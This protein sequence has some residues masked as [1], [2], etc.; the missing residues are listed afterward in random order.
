MHKICGGILLLLYSVFCIAKSNPPQLI[1]QI[2]IDQLR[3]DLIE[4]HKT[5]F[6]DKG[7]N[8]LLQHAI[9]FNNAHQPHA[10]TTTCVGH[11]SISTGS[12]PSLHGILDNEWYDRKTQ[13]LFYCVEDLNSPL[14]PTQHTRIK[15]PGRSPKSIKQSTLS[16]ELMLAK[17]GRAFAV[18]FKDRGAIT[19]GGHVGKAFWFDKKNGGFVTSQYYYSQYPDWVNAWNKAYQATEYEWTLANPIATY[20]NRNNKP[21][22]HN[23]LSFGQTFP[24]HVVNP[25]SNDYFKSVSRTP[26]GDQ[27]TADFAAQLLKNEHLGQSATQTDYLAVSFSSVDAVGHQ[28]GPNSL[29]AEDNL[30]ALDKTLAA[31]L[32]TLDK[33]VGLKNTLIIL[34]ADHG[35][36]DG[37]SYLREHQIA[38]I[39]P[40]NIANTMKF[41]RH[42]LMDRYQLPS[43]TLMS[44]TP[45][46]IYLNH[47]LIQ[48]RHL[49]TAEVSQYVAE[50]L[51]TLPGI[52]RAYP[53][54]TVAQDWLTRKVNRMAFPHRA[55]DIYIVQPPYQSYGAK[56]EDRVAHGS[57]WQYDSYIPLLFVH[58]DF[59]PQLISRPVFSVDIAPTL[60]N[61][62]KIKAPSG[63]VGQPLVEVIQAYTELKH[64]KA[65]KRN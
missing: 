63:V 26:K 28:F 52:F 53:L 8:Y 57:P 31:F 29:E 62:L 38:E 39:K 16:D 59:K 33:Q 12:Y 35:V 1:V 37:P 61:L 3:G 51:S 6:G 2:V 43:E 64:D 14:L 7:F 27:L 44:I 32:V 30:L 42:L 56:S 23:Y 58:P 65:G 10:N 9:D 34:T 49:Y 13:K 45:P 18:S 40:V 25:P 46:F 48:Q 4:R 20:R 11:A 17:Q 5:Q 22:K 21:F 60:A 24:H 41:I 47:E 19:L 15:N 55:G 36:S 54:P 50:Y